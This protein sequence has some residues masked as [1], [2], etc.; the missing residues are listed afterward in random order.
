LTTSKSQE[1][2]LQLIQYHNGGLP[3]VAPDDPVFR[4][5]LGG[6]ALLIRPEQPDAAACALAGWIRD[7][8]LARAAG[9]SRANVARWNAAAAEDGARFQRFLAGDPAAYDALESIVAHE[10]D[11]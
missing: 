3:V 1:I 10:G 7:G 11:G 6:S 8:A 4:E 2:R 9:M 5:V